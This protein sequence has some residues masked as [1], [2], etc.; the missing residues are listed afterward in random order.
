MAWG[1]VK[2]RELNHPVNVR[3]IWEGRE[4]SYRFTN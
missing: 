4:I 3:I 1:A 2:E